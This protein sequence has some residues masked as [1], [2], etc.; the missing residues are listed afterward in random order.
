MPLEGASHYKRTPTA[1]GIQYTFYCELTGLSVYTTTPI[2]ETD[3]QAAY[4]AAWG[5]AKYYF[6][7]CT[8]CSRWVSDLAYN[9]DDMQCVDCS[10]YQRKPKYCQQ[11]GCPIPSGERFCRRCGHAV[12]V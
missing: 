7:Q 8:K 12:A 11:C 6:N 2:T 3:L 10:P 5:E 9:I 1:Q 4:L